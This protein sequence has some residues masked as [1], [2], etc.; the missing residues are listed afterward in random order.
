M[1][2]RILIPAS[3]CHASGDYL[4]ARAS[5]QLRALET[6]KAWLFSINLFSNTRHAFHFCMARK[7]GRKYENMLYSLH[8]AKIAGI[9]Y[10]DTWTLN[11]ALN[12]NLMKNLQLFLKAI[13]HGHLRSNIFQHFYL[14]RYPNQLLGQGIDGSVLSISSGTSSSLAGRTKP[15]IGLFSSRWSLNPARKHGSL[16]NISIHPASLLNSLV[17]TSLSRT[18]CIS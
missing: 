1:Y 18:S 4:L 15:F 5:R 13:R 6:D 14:W 7:L 17:H 10:L 2:D 16:V 3:R 8:C 11:R 12:P 9:P